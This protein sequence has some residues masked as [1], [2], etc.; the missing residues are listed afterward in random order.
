MTQLFDMSEKILTRLGACR[1][2][3]VAVFLA[4]AIIPI[5]GFV[6]I[7][8]DVARAYLVKSRLSSALDAAALAGG[9]SFFLPTRDADIDMFFAANFPP[10]YLG[11]TVTGPIKFPDV[12]NE[13]LELT[14]SAV[15]PTSFMRILGFED[16]TVSAYSQVK[17]ELIALDVVL[18]IDMSGSMSSGAIGG[19]SRIAAARSAAHTLIDILF[20]TA[21]DKDLLGIGLV[22]WNSKVNVTIDGE[23]YDPALT[24]EDPV[25]AFSHPVTGAAQ[26]AVFSVNTSPVPLLNDPGPDWTG[27]VFQRYSDDGDDD[28][29]GDTLLDIGRIGTKDWVAWEPIGPD[30]DPLPGW[31]ECAMSVG[32]NECG[33]CLT[34]GITPLQHSKAVIKGKIDDLTSPQGQT[35]IPQGL[36]WAWRVLKPSAPFTEAIP[37][38]PYRRQQ[39]IL[40]L[41]DGENVGGSGDGYKGVWGTGGTAHDEMNSRL[42][43]LADNI[44]ADGVIVYVIQFANNDEDLKT[45]LKQVASGPDA[46]YYHLAPGAEELQTVFREVA[47]H[48]TELRLSK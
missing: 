28:N 46:P 25:A 6:G 12:D 26:S 31:N 34:H 22:P 20:G 21:P 7:G 17:R 18:A 11:A 23:I 45:L 44:K 33:P 32:G 37:D 24:T 42:Q 4:L 9:R 40:L 16:V 36:G 48:L 13:T 14:A 1:R 19:G 47:N 38:P 30:G 2:G 5:V 15:I 43:T 39:A 3:G 35:N 27:C 8:T 10:G 29:D 41:T